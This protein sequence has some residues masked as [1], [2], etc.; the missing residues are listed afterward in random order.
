MILF[1]SSFLSL[2]PPLFRFRAWAGRPAAAF[3]GRS[4]ARASSLR[5]GGHGRPDAFRGAASASFFSCDP[6]CSHALPYE[7]PKRGNAGNGKIF[8]FVVAKARAGMIFPLALCSFPG[9][10]VPEITT[11][12]VLHGP[13]RRGLF[14]FL[15]EFKNAS[16]AGPDRF[17]ASPDNQDGACVLPRIGC[18]DI[19]KGYFGKFVRG[20]GETRHD[21]LGREKIVVSGMDGSVRRQLCSFPGSIAPEITTTTVI[22]GPPWRGPFLIPWRIQK[23]FPNGPGSLRGEPG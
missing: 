11:R 6:C 22:H 3:L 19:G 15:G 10:L 18:L 16:Q 23:R 21:R 7:D 5:A 4:P 14:L 20:S 8:Y 13:P 12:T 1:L 17:V 2:C 9:S